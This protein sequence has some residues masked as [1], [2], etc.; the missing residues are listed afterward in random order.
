M[1]LMLAIGIPVLFIFGGALLAFAVSSAPVEDEVAVA[2]P[3]VEQARPAAQGFF[4]LPAGVAL[5]PGDE[6]S[7]EAQILALE[8][9][10]KREQ[11]AAQAFAH[12][13]SVESLWAEQRYVQ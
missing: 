12:N 2:E 13:P 9:H 3:A 11:Q 7:I 10:L 1:V 4:F 8:A 5:K 6:A